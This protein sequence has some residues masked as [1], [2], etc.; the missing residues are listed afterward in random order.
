MEAVSSSN[1]YPS[2]QWDSALDIPLKASEEVVSID[3]ETDL[4]EDPADLRTLLVEESSDKEHWLTIAVAYC[5][6]GKIDEGIKLI[7]MALETFQNVEKAP[8]HTF[9]TWAHLKKAKE[10]SVNKEE[11][12]QELN[13]AEMHLKD[14]I[15][16]DPTWVGNM[17][18]T[19]DLYY[20]RNQYDKALE[21]TDIFMK[22]IATEDHRH[23]RTTK[24]NC[25]FILIRAK[26]LY[27][28]NNYLASLRLFQELLVLNPVLQP[29]PRIGIGLCFWQLKDY[30]MAIKSWKRALEL[31]P[32]DK[33]AEIL[34]LL[35]DFHKSL[36]ESSNDNQFSDY[37]TE[38]L[39]NLNNLYSNNKENP[40]LLT[41]LQSYFYFKG[42]YKAVLDIHENKISK[43]ASITT[44]SVLSDSAFWCARAHY[45]LHDYRKA[46]TM[47][48]ESLR[49]NEDN[50][51]AKF[52]LGQT[53]FKTNL[54]EESILTFENLYKSFEG[55]Q[56]LNY[57]LGLLYSG[58]VLNLSNILPHSE[59]QKLIAKSIQ[60][61]E[62]Y[63]KLT[64][65]KK[66][67]LVIPK[68]YLILSELYEIQ[69]NYKQSLEYLTKA[70]E[71]AKAINKDEIPF[72][73]LNNIGC[74]YFI[75]GDSNKAIEY[76]EFAKERLKVY[77]ID[78]KPSEVT[79]SY[80]IARTTE[81]TDISKANSMYEDI[82]G[83]HPDYIH[84]KVRSL[85]AKFMING[86][87]D[88]VSIEGEVENLMKDNS[89]DLEVRSFYS[90][91]LKN[92]M[93]DTANFDEKKYVKNQEIETNNN[94][95][96]LVKFNSH[97]VFALN[98]MGNFYNYLAKENKRN[99][100][101]A[102]QYYLK[103]IQLFQKALQVDP[104]NVFAAQGLA[105]IFAECKRL[106]PSLE[107]L[108]KIRDSLDTED[109]HLNLANCLLEMHEYAK[110]IEEY[111]FILKRFLD[112][113]N[114]AKIYNLLG[115]TWYARG[116][117]E[118]SHDCY[119]KSL[120]NAE[121]ALKMET[122]KENGTARG[123]KIMSFKYN[124]ALLHFQI[125]ETLRRADVRD[126]TVEDVTNALEGLQ[127]ALIMLKDIKDQEFK[128]IAKDELEQRIQLGET[129]MKSALERCKIEQEQYEQEQSNKLDE[130]RKI[131][132][133]NEQKKLERIE[134]EKEIERARLEKK[135]EEF[136][137][138][139]EEAQ[140][141]IEERESAI[142]N[143]PSSDEDRDQE[144][145][146]NVE[147]KS[148]KKAKRKRSST[149]EG[150]TKKRKANKPKEGEDDEDEVIS[151]T[152][153]RRG[154]KSVLSEEFIATS[155]EED[156]VVS[157]QGNEEE[158]KEAHNTGSS[159]NDDDLF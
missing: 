24:P 138:L 80:N 144:D 107:I 136:L 19:I 22:G 98:S 85:I 88:G 84:L 72:E 82:L 135:R 14:A 113:K 105:I 96:T 148:A 156:D 15:G 134:K 35:G 38:A 77:D 34:V 56:E 130:A 110:A 53:Q 157:D 159:D 145:Y 124:V 129:T 45:S 37:Y 141:I 26:L 64:T 86:G 127:V 9:L 70:M 109:V 50:L 1:G 89:S 59:S 11:K 55:I 74:F 103:S 31:N 114:S 5:N 49:K 131:L 62:K 146:E 158:E 69:N 140:K 133:E 125:A 101:K 75:T 120:K 13:Q 126:R 66:N 100:E 71:D 147:E 111:E 44:N 118:K 154:K 33:S 137:K 83:R 40:V 32:K 61:L 97:D 79:L 20:E 46:F 41:L 102:K 3:L 25:F 30:K 7:E 43:V 90:W 65:T 151:K 94:K 42:D 17:L 119:K 142:V 29:D 4:P 91:F 58:K 28:K 10:T 117:K 153:G 99:P 2:M 122:E 27:Q 152:N 68:A 76:F 143:E 47:F 18:A 54:L 6:Q 87:K 123:S 57:I 81:T 112:S 150:K 63:V 23:G 139:Q 104:L 60:Y 73:I 12:N 51:L 155:D 108:R 78:T 106:G 115:R 21:T 92:D 149:S 8:L 36:T 132:E 128:L 121:T 116:N 48:Q 52:G 93:K 95:E 39:K 67:Q 16:F